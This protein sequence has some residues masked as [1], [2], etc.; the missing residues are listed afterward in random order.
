MLV[1]IFLADSSGN[2]PIPSYFW[3][4]RLDLIFKEDFDLY[5]VRFRK[6]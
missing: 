6:V 1:P 4:I 5:L 3:G 2:Y